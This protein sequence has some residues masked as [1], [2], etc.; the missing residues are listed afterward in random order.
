[1]QHQDATQYDVMLHD[2]SFFSF[3]HRPSYTT[4]YPEVEYFDQETIM[5][6]IRCDEARRDD[7]LAKA[8]REWYEV[9]P[10]NELSLVE[11]R[12]IKL[13]KKLDSEV[14]C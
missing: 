3:K 10:N 7:L 11:H 2:G 5:Q 1:M 9:N 6:Q 4:T 12:I 8:S 13:L 14:D